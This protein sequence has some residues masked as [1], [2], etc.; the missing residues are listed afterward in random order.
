MRR[1]AI[2]Q[3]AAAVATLLTSAVHAQ[4]RVVTYN[5]AHLDGD[6]SALRAVLAHL[7]DD[8]D[9]ETGTIR[10]P[11]LY[12][13][14]EVVP[15]DLPAIESDLE[16]AAPTGTNYVRAT[17][18]DNAGNDTEQALFFRDDTIDE[19]TG[20]YRSL[21]NH[22][23]P[24]PTD[25]WQVSLVDSPSTVFY[26]Y[27]SHLKA[28]TS[29]D[30][31][32]R[33]ASE[34]N[35]I[36]LDADALG[37]ANIIYAGDYNLY[38]PTE[39]AFVRFFDAGHGKAVDARFNRSFSNLSHSQ[40]PFDTNSGLDLVGG[41]MDD[42]F[43]FLLVSEELADGVA[44]FIRALTYRSFGNDGNHYNQPVNAGNNAYFHSSEQFK[45]DDLAVASDHL[46]VVADFVVPG[47][48]F[49]LDVPIL[50]AGAR[51]TIR[52]TGAA[53]NTTVFFYYSRVGLGESYIGSLD[54]TLRLAAPLLA[55]RSR[56]DSAGVSNLTIGIPSNARGLRV[57]IQAAQ[58]GRSTDPVAETVL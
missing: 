53:P 20:G 9:P 13:L 40:S 6:R 27:G 47:D 34:V 52:A 30:D 37:S 38:G 5:I 32:D 21:S 18:T 16:A 28:D 54:V 56:A 41:G 29:T 57:W 14:Q 36:R 8:P 44:P 7:S 55:G 31:Q 12:V 17:F 39:P 2:A 1:S 25:R 33:R 23:G 35:A 4:L 26:V 46:P 19:I 10:C 49:V 48:P 43:D 51:P 24:R 11:D 50:I 15:S 3:A 45:A 42:R 58:V 22:D